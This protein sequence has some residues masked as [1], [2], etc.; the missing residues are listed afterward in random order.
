[1]L[2]IKPFTKIIMNKPI[3]K[4]K[5]N[6]IVKIYEMF[7]RDGLQSLKPYTFEQKKLF[8][9]Q[10][11]KNNFSCIEFGSTTN[12]KLLPQ[13]NNSF[14]LWDYIENHEKYNNKI[15][16]TMLVPHKLNECIASN[17]R[18]FGLICTISDNFAKS[19]LKK[20]ADESINNMFNQLNKI[21]LLSNYHVRI[22][23]SCSFGEPPDGNL[24]IESF[25]KLI[26]LLETI[27]IKIKENYIEP[28][29]L[30]IV[31][32]DTVGSISEEKIDELLKNVNPE[33][34]D[35]VSLHLHSDKNFY[36]YINKSLEYNVKKFDSSLL[37]IGGCPFAK[38][39]TV[40]NISTYS[41]VKYLHSKGYNTHLSLTKLKETQTILKDLLKT[42]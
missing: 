15:N 20:T 39:E 22:Y 13:M 24:E 12:S 3:N 42:F 19:N 6:Y 37:G 8:L 29:N 25:N 27:N 21:V 1:M 41:L 7:M 10:I 16:Y 11:M 28:D 26:N 33:L 36:P 30:D 14:E 38:K 31:F 2:I 35:Y 17:I 40:G 5:K 34:I 23:I 32:A 18:S 4:I 9:N